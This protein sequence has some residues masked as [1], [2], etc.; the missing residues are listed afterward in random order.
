M[1]YITFQGRDLSH[2]YLAYWKGHKIIHHIMK[3]S[4]LHQQ[5]RNLMAYTLPF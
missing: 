5:C 2:I 1:N 3:H 4:K